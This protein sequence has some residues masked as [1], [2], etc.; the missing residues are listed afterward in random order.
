MEGFDA[1]PSR[2]TRYLY[3]VIGAE[4]SRVTRHFDRVVQWRPAAHD[5]GA[6]LANVAGREKS[7]AREIGDLPDPAGERE[8]RTAVLVNGNFNHHMDIQG[9]LAALKPRLART[10]RLVVVLYNPYLRWAYGIADALGLRNAPPPATFLTRTDLNDLARLSGFEVVR[11]RTSGYSPFRL[12]GLGHLVNWWMPVVP[13]LQWLSFVVVA[14]LRPVVPETRRP[15]IS[16]VVPARNEK[17]NIEGAVTRL[18]DLRAERVEIVFVENNS[19]DDTWPE[20]QR[21]AAKYADRFDIKAFSHPCKGKAEAVHIGFA[22]STC[23]LVVILDCDLTMPPELLGRFYDAYCGGLADFVNGSRLLYP[24]EN[25][26]MRFLNRLGN[27]FFAKALSYVLG[28]RL[29]DSLCGTKLFPRHDWAR[30][31]AWREE[32]GDFDPFGDFE[33][34]FPASIF[35]LGILDVPIRYRARTYGSTNIKRFRHG[36]MLFLMTTTA[37]FRV[38]TGPWRLNPSDAATTPRSR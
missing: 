4:T 12:L 38:R 10:A 16:I 32:F 31:V 33:M 7:V 15:S 14:V 37:L 25:E 27:V 26:A 17:G 9:E 36:W 2:W 3:R 23:E 8:K 19:T 11:L 18:P 28:A 13:G 29:A 22:Q 34:L 21:V 24:M 6:L 35:G 1:P 30:F 5:S 20:I